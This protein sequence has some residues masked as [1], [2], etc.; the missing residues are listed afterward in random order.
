MRLR[1]DNMSKKE[2]EFL[3]LTKDRSKI[4]TD[5]I[6]DCVHYNGDACKYNETCL[7]LAVDHYE[8]KPKNTEDEEV[9]YWENQAMGC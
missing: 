9:R 5:C 1:R 8:Q 3:D 7:R 4:F 6:S 2:D